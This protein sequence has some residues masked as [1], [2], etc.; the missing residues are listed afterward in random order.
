MEYFTQSN[1]K[2]LIN[3]FMFY[4]NTNKNI[5][6]DPLSCLI[7]LAILGYY[8]SGTKISIYNNRILY[9]H[10]SILQGAFRFFNGDGKEDL[11]NL[12][13]PLLKCLEWYWDENNEDIKFLFKNSIFG[14]KKLKESYKNNLMIQHLLN[15]FILI[16]NSKDKK[17][18][19]NTNNNIQKNSQRLQELGDIYDI[20]EINQ[21]NNKNNEINNEI[22]SFLK[23]LWNENEIK[24]IIQLFKEFIYKHKDKNNTKEEINNFLNTIKNIVKTKEDKLFK[25]IA[26]FTTILK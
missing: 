14:I 22:H 15:Y 19:K 6:L 7:K 21:E 5:I 20:K 25:F 17:I 11:H 13:N 24:I 3:K 23:N 16:L 1:L 4:E 18:N 12:Y 9:N 2:L 8:E 10:P 26:N